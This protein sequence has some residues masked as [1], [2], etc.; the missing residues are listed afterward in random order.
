MSNRHNEYM[1]EWRAKNEEKNK[2]YQR[3]YFKQYYTSEKREE[4]RERARKW[5]KDNKEKVKEWGKR[6]Y[7]DNK[8]T[9]NERNKIWAA[10]NP[11][12]LRKSR[13]K[14]T[15]KR[16]EYIIAYYSNNTNKCECCNESNIEFLTVDHINGDGAQHRREIGGGHLYH[17]L[18]KNKYPEGFRIL[19]LNCNFSLGQYGYCPHVG[20]RPKVSVCHS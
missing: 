9:V 12:S 14:F 16:K 13:K 15:R 11:E 18:T 2:L 19:C 6:Y 5:Y 10:K 1:R 4:A 8:E 3:E 20:S 17:W 7:E